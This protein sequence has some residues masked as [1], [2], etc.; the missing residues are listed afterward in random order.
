METTLS[1]ATFGHT[2]GDY[3]VAKEVAP[4]HSVDLGEGVTLGECW[5]LIE[6]RTPGVAGKLMGGAPAEVAVRVELNYEKLYCGLNE[7]QQLVGWKPWQE[8]K[9]GEIRKLA[10]LGLIDG[11]DGHIRFQDAP[12]V[13]NGFELLFADFVEALR[14]AREVWAAVSEIASTVGAALVAAKWWTAHLDRLSALVE[15]AETY[16]DDLDARNVTTARWVWLLERQEV[17]VEAKM[18]LLGVGTPDREGVSE[19]LAAPFAVDQLR[20]LVQVVTQHS[21]GEEVGLRL[22][23]LGRVLMSLGEP[24]L[25]PS[26]ASDNT[27]LQYVCQ[28]PK[29]CGVLAGVE[30]MSRDHLKL[31]LTA[32]SDHFVMRRDRWLQVGYQR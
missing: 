9:L 12:P 22:A 2:D 28:C 1:V 23:Y 11:F 32:D 18:D 21:H 24:D 19:A 25:A 17:N 13:G 4:D 20:L 6:E 15:L 3:T 26:G 8:M 30:S 10:D 29:K 5:Q 31:G 7:N 16:G 27:D 14:I